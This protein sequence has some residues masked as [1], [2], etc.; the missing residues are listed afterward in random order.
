MRVLSVSQRRFAF[1]PQGH[2]V[3][4]RSV[5]CFGCGV[6]LGE[7]CRHASVVRGGYRKCASRQVAPSSGGQLPVLAQ[8]CNDWAVLRTIGNHG[9]PRMIL[10]RTTHQRRT[11]DIDQVDA[12][13]GGKW[14]QSHAYEVDRFDVVTREIL[15]VRGV[16]GVGENP[17]VHR[18]VQRHHSMSENRRVA[19]YIG[20]VHHGKCRR[21]QNLRGTSTCEQSPSKLV[22]RPRKVHHSRLVVH[23][24]QRSWHAP[25]LA[26]HDA[27]L[28]RNEPL[29]HHTNTQRSRDGCK[30][31]Q[32]QHVPQRRT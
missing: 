9:N 21:S 11:T 6:F 7:P 22:Q 23:A 26:Q 31:H 28:L 19:G 1:Q 12:G 27:R 14:V 15:A 20:N 13:L 5:S 2:I 4:Q 3:R 18:R 17:T 8:L 16:V 30:H 29:G 25:I 10:G 32:H 24:E